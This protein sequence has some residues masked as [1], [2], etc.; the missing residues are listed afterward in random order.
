MS[1]IPIQIINQFFEIEQKINHQNQSSLFERNFN[2]LKVLFEEEGYIIQNPVNES[3]N[4]SRTDCEASIVGK[5][6][7]KMKISK[8][9]KPVI[10]KKSDNNILL[11]QKAVVF[12]ESI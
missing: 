10:Y 12:V 1:N 6:T 11:I 9:L 8:T 4:D 7:S 5:V 2:K 3:Y